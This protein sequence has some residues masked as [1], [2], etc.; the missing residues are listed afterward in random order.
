MRF[1]LA[2]LLCALS[3]F[4][5]GPAKTGDRKIEMRWFLP[6]E[7]PAAV[8]SW[9][10]PN[11]GAPEERTDTYLVVAGHNAIGLKL[12]GSE[13]ELKERVAAQEVN[14][15]G[16][17]FSGLVETWAKW[18]WIV[19]S[20]KLPKKKAKGKLVDVQKARWQRQFE[21]GCAAELTSVTAAGNRWWTVLVEGPEE[22][23]AQAIVKC[24]DR[25][26]TDYPGPALQVSNSQSYPGWLLGLFQ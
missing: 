7:I 15:A 16:R 5:A 24:A 14:F 8:K 9:F 13:L 12:R 4:A 11:A 26:F 10:D 20:G 1:F 17:R 18:E 19:P 3:A 25:V 23:D 6:G 2:T 21:D 22:A